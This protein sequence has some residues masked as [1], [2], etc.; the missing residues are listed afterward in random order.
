VRPTQD[1]RADPVRA[2]VVRPGQ[3]A[4]SLR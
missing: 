3:V 4:V 1:K 2:Q